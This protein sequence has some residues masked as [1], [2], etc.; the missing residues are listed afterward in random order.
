MRA[1]AWATWAFLE[2][3]SDGPRRA[4]VERLLRASDF[5]F[6]VR[7]VVAETFRFVV[8]RTGQIGQG[9]AWWKA[10]RQSRVRV[11]E[12]PLDDVYEFAASQGP[13][14]SLNFTDLALAYV[15]GREGTATVASEDAEFRRLKLNP[16][17]AR[18]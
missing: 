4:E 18:R 8:R 17:F 15:A 9:L 5:V 7:E 14:G 13:L 1:V 2:V 16:V 10:L 11:F 12:P 6:T 3:L